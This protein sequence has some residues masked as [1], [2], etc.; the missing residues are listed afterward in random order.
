[1]AT[2][3]E[4]PEYIDPP[5]NADPPAGERQL[6]LPMTTALVIGNMIGAGI[7]LL[8]AVLAPLGP[9]AIYGWLVTIA[10]ALFIAATLAILSA[11][12]EG[13]PFAYVEEAFG[14]KFAFVVMWSYL[15]SIWT[16]VAVLPIAAVS[17]LSH[18]APVLGHP[19]VAPL[20]SIGFAW[21]LMLV[22]ATG[23]RNAGSVQLVTSILKALPLIA[24]VVVAA[25]YLGRGTATAHAMPVAVSTGSIATA[26]SL[27]LFSMLGSESAVVSTD[28]VKNPRRNLPIASVL[29]AA[30]T[31]V[32]YLAATAAVL[33]LLP[34]KQA[35]ASPS[36][37]A[38]ATQP[39]IGP[40]AGSAIAIFAAISALGCLN[41][42]ILCVGEVPL[43]LARDG[44]LPAWFAKTTG[45]GTPVRAQLV[46]CVVGSVLIAMNYSR[47][48]ASAFEFITLI[49][50]VS[51]LVLYTGCAAA[52]LVLFAR[53]GIGGIVLAGCA[54]VAFLFS[55]WSYWGAGREATLWGAA[56]VATGWPVWFIA[57][58]SRRV[59]ASTSPP[60]EANQAAPL[61]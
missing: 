1:M 24:V 6:G 31:G 55:I 45:R 25:I 16:T 3:T 35:A 47:S 5:I 38:D 14:P 42:W 60:A 28:K 23:A 40:M 10:G 57:Q 39:L 13:G 30:L 26:A 46:G 37:F 44:T 9:N 51:T 36:P 43:K 2:T 7:F 18:V 17:N 15:V 22:N 29:G 32:I 49:A 53:R 48:L 4:A 12:I 33:Y 34:G 59:S 19:I 50:V 20:V 11:H 56:L 41:G 27:A 8:P 61:E 21:L 54:A 58:R 52:A